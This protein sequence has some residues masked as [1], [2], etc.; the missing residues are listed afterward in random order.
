M[1]ILALEDVALNTGVKHLATDWQVMDEAGNVVLESINDKK[2]LTSIVFTENLDV[3]KTWKGQARLRCTD[4]TTTWV[5]LT[6]LVNKSAGLGGLTDMPSRIEPPTISTQ[7][8]K[9]DKYVDGDVNNHDI[10]MFRILASDFK[11]LGQATHYATSWIIEDINGEVIWSSLSNSIYKNYIDVHDLIL[12]SNAIYR[13]KVIFHGSNNNMS[14][15]STYTIHTADGSDVH[16]NTYIDNVESNEPLVLSINELEGVT[17]VK[18]T[19]YGFINDIA[20]ETY[21]STETGGSCFTTI[22]P[23]SAYSNNK[24]YL[25]KIEPLDSEYHTKYIPFRTITPD[26][27]TGESV[28]INISYGTGEGNSSINTTTGTIT[29]VLD[30]DATNLYI[31]NNNQDVIKAEIV[32]VEEDGKIVKKL[33]VSLA[34]TFTYDENKGFKGNYTITIVGSRD[35]YD[36]FTYNAV[37]N[38]DLPSIEEIDDPSAIAVTLSSYSVGLNRNMR[39]YTLTVITEADYVG[40]NAQD[41]DTSICNV[42]SLGNKQYKITGNNRAKIGSAVVEFVTQ[43]IDSTTGIAYK[44]RRVKCTVGVSERLYRYTCRYCKYSH[45]QFCPG[46]YSGLV[47][48]ATNQSGRWYSGYKYKPTY[49]CNACGH[50][51]RSYSVFWDTNW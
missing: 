31:I 1:V 50:E 14:S 12:Q 27:Y 26:N 5:D 29:G 16:L 18:W 21:S 28:K 25:L 11:C 10:T 22:I 15:V 43:M 32:E 20:Y 6:V 3:N 9:N 35:N 46:G 41:L 48:Y 2:N 33:V 36:D 34:D 51:E 7:V 42:T 44:E 17:S 47:H 19:V 8:I 30:T 24:I 37:I 49:T 38:I 13:I 45:D 4:L 40:I 23:V 39:E